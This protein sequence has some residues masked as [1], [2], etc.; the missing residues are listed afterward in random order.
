MGGEAGI[1]TIPA[2]PDRRSRRRAV[3]L[4]TPILALSAASV[5]GNLLAPA[6]VT[7]HPL[8][9][10]TLSPRAVYLAIAAG[11][12]P[13]AAYLAVGL[14]RL[15]AADPSHFLLGSLLGSRVDRVAARLPRL[16]RRMGLPV[17]ALC[18]NGKVLLLAGATGLPHR[19]VALAAVTG[20]LAQLV[21]IYTA[22]RALATPLESVAGLISA[23]GP[24]AVPVLAAVGGGVAVGRAGIRRR[25][26]G[27]ALP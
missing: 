2:S 19:R 13:P 25:A 27:R 8:L 26:Q 11:E 17:V 18:P 21:L 1:A 9:L 14:L 6:L 22:S 15:C 24:L 16:C 5:I 4:A 10:I 3:L 7:A 23:V 12:V 20:T